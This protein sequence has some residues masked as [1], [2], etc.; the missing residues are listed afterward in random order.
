MA[1][2]TVAVSITS[3]IRMRVNSN[4]PAQVARHRPAYMPARLPKAQAPKAAVSQHRPMAE[5]ATGRRATQSETPKT[6]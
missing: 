1:S 4:S 3:G 5:S 6:L 2:A